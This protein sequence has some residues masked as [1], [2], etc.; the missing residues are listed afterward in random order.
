MEPSARHYY[1]PPVRW[2]SGALRVASLTSL[3]ICG[4]MLL[5][6]ALF[7]IVLFADYLSFFFGWAILFAW[8]DS[9]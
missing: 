5:A 7:G 9:L 6:E 2:R 4:A 1:L 8:G 3:A